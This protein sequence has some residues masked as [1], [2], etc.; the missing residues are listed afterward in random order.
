[1]EAPGFWDNPE[2]SK[3]KMKE[4]K[5]LKDLVETM[6]HLRDQYEDIITVIEMGNEE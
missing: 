6:D 1:M 2:V 4:L 3:T 5:K